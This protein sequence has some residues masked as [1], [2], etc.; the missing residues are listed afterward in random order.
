[1]SVALVTGSS[2]LVGSETA[3]LFAARGFS[4][5]GIDN[6]MRRYFFGA[7]GNNDWSLL[8]NQVEIP[9]YHHESVD[10]RDYDG[11]SKIFQKYGN[12]IACVVHTAAQPS[13]DWAA[14]EPLTDFSVNAFGTLNL[15]ELTRLF[16]AD[17][18]FVCT[19]TNKVYGDMPNGLP[20]VELET[21]YELPDGMGW[22][23]GIDESMSIDQCLHSLFG[24]SKLAS[25]VLVQEYGRYFGLKTAVFRAGCITGSAHSGAK[26]HGFL[27]YLVK[28]ALS[29]TPYVIYGYGGKQVRDNIHALDLAEAF[30]HYV[31]APRQGEVYNIG[32]GRYCNTSV[33]EAIQLI[34]KITGQ[35]IDYSLSDEA[36]I[37]DHKWWISDFGKFASHYPGWKLTYTIADLIEEIAEGLQIRLTRGRAKSRRPTA[38]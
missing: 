11:L 15:L 6:G 36:R 22:H 23:T 9:G 29:G 16:C 30:W 34:E 33:I 21:R 28:C 24:A 19:S 35:L 13:H 37:G 38:A 5:V 14:Q 1:M 25:D 20:L 4:I 27:N 2:G 18:A 10:I 26:L 8:R 7:D 31:Q 12:S 17:A 32:G 3:R